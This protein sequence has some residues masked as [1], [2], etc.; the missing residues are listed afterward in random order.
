LCT[1]FAVLALAIAC[2]GLYGTTSYAIVRRTKEIGIRMALGAQRGRVMRMILS[3]VFILVIVGVAAGLPI[4]RATTQL[5]AS[6]LYGVKPGDP[7]AIAAAVGP[8]AAAAL[9]AAYLPARRASRIDPMI[10]LRY[11]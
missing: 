3:E 1:I 6:F 9:V 4:A 8:L 10:T 5:V 11:E 7:L 2:V